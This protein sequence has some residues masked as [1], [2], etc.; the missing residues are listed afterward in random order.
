MK[1][2]PV[3]KDFKIWLEV[4]EL[5]FC[6]QR[7]TG[8]RVVTRAASQFSSNVSFVSQISIQALV[9]T[10]DFFYCRRHKS[11]AGSTWVQ[12]W[13]T[14]RAFVF[15]SIQIH[16]RERVRS[17]FFF[18]GRRCSW[19]RNSVLFCCRNFILRSQEFASQL[20]KQDVHEV[21]CVS[22]LPC[23]SALV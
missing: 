23:S 2:I 10:R 20:E 5:Q 16:T 6:C 18:V 15:H 4:G 13:W 17:G 14:Q 7:L 3:I 19:R 12:S 21:S 1:L 9:I 11:V 22:V 8:N